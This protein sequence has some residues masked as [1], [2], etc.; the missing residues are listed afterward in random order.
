MYIFI[1]DPLFKLVTQYL[2]Q[3]N[4]RAEF[5]K[6]WFFVVLLI[7]F[8]WKAQRCLLVR[9]SWKFMF[10]IKN[11][12]F[13]KNKSIS[14]IIWFHGYGMTVTLMVTRFPGALTGCD[15]VLDHLVNILSIIN[16]TNSKRSIDEVG[17]CRISLQTW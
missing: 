12:S 1:F 10:R 13:I 11:L 6:R 8:L 7:G 15:D 16:R 3:V 17:I 5:R 4:G 14:V 2:F 9:T